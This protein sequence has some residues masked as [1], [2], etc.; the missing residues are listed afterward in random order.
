MPKQLIL[1]RDL[2]NP[3]A[4][5]KT[6]KCWAEERRG[7]RANVDLK[8]GNSHAAFLCLFFL[9]SIKS[10]CDRFAGNTDVCNAL[11]NAECGMHDVVC[12]V[13]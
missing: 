13:Y 10:E 8:D 4:C 2:L 11:K 12:A 6:E 7:L 1:S 5:P 9:F 3:V